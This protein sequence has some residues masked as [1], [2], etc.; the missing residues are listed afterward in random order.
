MAS[1]RRASESGRRAKAE[2]ERWDGHCLEH[3]AFANGQGLVLSVHVQDRWFTPYA[4][5]DMKAVIK[6]ELVLK[7]GIQIVGGCL[8][9]P[10]WSSTRVFFQVVIPSSGFA[11]C[12]TWWGAGVGYSIR[13]FERGIALKV[14]GLKIGGVQSVGGCLGELQWFSPRVFFQMVAPSAGLAIR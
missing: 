6:T 8:G 13:V 10:Q 5:P 1:G 4:F 12:R 11:L 7:V 9:K 14:E 2:G 3:G